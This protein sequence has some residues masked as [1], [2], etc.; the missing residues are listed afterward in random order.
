MQGRRDPS[1]F[2]TKKNPAPTEEGEGQMNLGNSCEVSGCRQ[3]VGV[4]QVALQ[5]VREP[6]AQAICGLW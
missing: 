3:G 4:W 2:L 6:D 5:P 1:F